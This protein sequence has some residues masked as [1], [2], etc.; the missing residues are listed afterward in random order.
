MSLKFLQNSLLV[1]VIGV[2]TACA[3]SSNKQNDASSEAK[4]PQIVGNI[5]AGSPFSKLTIGMSSKQ[6]HDLI[7]EPTDTVNYMTGKM[8]IPFYFGS[9]TMRLDELYKGQGRITYTGAGVGGVN[10]HV[11]RIVFDANEDGYNND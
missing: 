10:F 6:V 7:G 4:E 8:F 2:L 5:P 3:S 11:Y 9:D 1:L